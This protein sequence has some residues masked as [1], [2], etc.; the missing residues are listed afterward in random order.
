MG[1]H[2]LLQGYLYFYSLLI[3]GFNVHCSAVLQ[4]YLYALLEIRPGRTK[5][6]G[7][8]K[9]DFVGENQRPLLVN[10]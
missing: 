4:S 2:G 1:V 3:P 5:G 6:N 10:S 9:K 7:E 8:T